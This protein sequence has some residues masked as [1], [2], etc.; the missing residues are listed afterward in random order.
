MTVN[1]AVEVRARVELRLATDGRY[2]I[3]Q[4]GQRVEAGDLAGLLA[5][6]S[7]AL[8][9]LVLAELGIPPVELELR[10]DSPRGGGLGGSS[11]L[12]VALLAAGELLLEGR[13]VR[14]PLARAALAR[15]LEARLLGLPTGLQDHLPAQ[16]GGALAIEHLPGGERV[17]RL[18][19]DLEALG[20]RLLVAFSGESHF[21]AANNWAILRRR[22]EADPPTVAGLDAIRDVAALLPEALERGDWERV[23]ALVDREWGARRTLA[24][25]VSTERVEAL[26]AA[27]RSRGAWGGKVCGA[28]GGGSLF[29]LAPPERRA[30]IAEVWRTQGARIL[31][32]AP[33]ARGLESE[34]DVP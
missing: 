23:G 6:P 13:R 22:F 26:L 3:Q 12:T 8:P 34:P 29:V 5:E 9:G 24:P 15:D 27:A 31:E 16:L 28:G 1:V 25:E 32:A 20:A 7:A 14:E 30:A 11:A 21:S 4:E 10:S 33:T 18:D 2:R 19:V 17:R